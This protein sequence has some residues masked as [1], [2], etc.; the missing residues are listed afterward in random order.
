MYF[1]SG[2]L[3]QMTLHWLII[4]F[5][6]FSKGTQH[7]WSVPVMSFQD[8][9]YHF[10]VSL[11]VSK[12]QSM[13]GFQTLRGSSVLFDPF[14]V[15]FA[16]IK[17]VTDWWS[18]SQC[19]FHW[20]SEVSCA[21]EGETSSYSDYHFLIQSSCVWGGR[22]CAFTIHHIFPVWFHL[23]AVVMGSGFVSVL[24]IIFKD[25]HTEQTIC[26]CPHCIPLHMYVH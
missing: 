18:L 26:H 16:G 2:V 8:V 19:A 24:Y 9:T 14:I 6:L 13:R 3:L 1:P 17:S 12:L 7:L 23:Y 25:I 4:V 22:R 21:T 15:H 10:R 11:S 20:Q 5:I